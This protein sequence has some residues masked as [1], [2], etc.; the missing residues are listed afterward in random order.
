[1]QNGLPVWCSTQNKF[2]LDRSTQK[3]LRNAAFE[4]FALPVSSNGL[5]EHVRAELENLTLRSFYKRD[6][7]YAVPGRQSV[8]LAEP[9]PVW[10]MHYGLK[11]LMSDYDWF[12]GSG[13]GSYVYPTMGGFRAHNHFH[14]LL[15]LFMRMLSP[16]LSNSNNSCHV[17][18]DKISYK[19]L[20]VVSDLFA[21]TSDPKSFDQP[22]GSPR[23]RFG[24]WWSPTIFFCRFSFKYFGVSNL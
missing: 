16:N 23:K 14:L 4:P 21:T 12:D 3:M 22:G 1:M 19:L 7:K 18:S 6:K 20:S 13:I 5:R 24:Y 8:A 9:L 15:L 2:V 17:K 10:L 11:V